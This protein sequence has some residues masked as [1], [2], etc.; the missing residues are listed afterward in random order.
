MSFKEFVLKIRLKDAMHYLENMTMT[1]SDIAYKV[2]YK[3]YNGF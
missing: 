1:I 3:P 2:G